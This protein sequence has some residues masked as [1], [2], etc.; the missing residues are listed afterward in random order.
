MNR[1]TLRIVIFAL[2][3]SAWLAGT[4]MSL[5]QQSVQ[6][7]TTREGSRSTGRTGAAEILPHALPEDPSAWP[8]PNGGQGWTTVGQSMASPYPTVPVG[9]YFDSAGLTQTVQPPP[10]YHVDTQGNVTFTS[11]VTGISQTFGSSVQSLK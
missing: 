7:I 9:E 1:M 11:P 4:C 2:T 5:A 10:Q 3:S 8:P 6:S